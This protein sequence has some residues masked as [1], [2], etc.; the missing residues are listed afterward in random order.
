MTHYG[1]RELAASF[2]TVRNNTMQVASE[3]P[4]NQYNFKAA[5][6]TRTVGE[7]LIHIALGPSFQA[8]IHG[9][10]IDDLAHVDFAALMKQNAIDE[11]KPRNKAE[12]LALLK[13]EGE[14]FAHYLEGL[15]DGF[16]A[17][18][19]KMPQGADPATKSRLEMLMSPKEHEMHHRGQLMLIQ[20]QI[21][22]TPHLTRQREERMAQAAARAAEQ[23]AQPAHR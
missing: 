2:R 16:L 13:T 15:S 11:G 14:K 4:E 20:R 19:V 7:L 9:N 6:G 22:I 10:R 12:I 23:S 21:G 8:Y 5:P 3:I 17:E 18:V 1:A